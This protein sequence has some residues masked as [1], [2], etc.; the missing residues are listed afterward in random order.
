MPPQLDDEVLVGFLDDDP[1]SA[2]VLAGLYGATA[3]PP[4]GPA[5]PAAGRGSAL[6]TAG[7][8]RLDLDPTADGEPGDTG[9]P[10]A[11]QPVR[12]G[13][14]LVTPDGRRL[15]LAEHAGGFRLADRSG[16]VLA[17]SDAGTELTTGALTVTAQGDVAITGGSVDLG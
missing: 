4:S 12:A 14:V 7:G 9:S 1:R 3:E 17:L 13:L 8:T 5:R 16:N 11:D 15:E 10:S 6:V 2:V